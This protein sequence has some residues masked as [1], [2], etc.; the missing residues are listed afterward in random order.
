ML[1]EREKNNIR[2][3]ASDNISE[4]GG[5]IHAFSTRIGGVSGPPFASLN[6]NAGDADAPEN[7]ARNRSIF[8]DAIGL[9]CAEEK[10]LVTLNQ[11]HGD[12]VIAI[13]AD[14]DFKEKN[15]EPPQGGDAMITDVVGTPIGILTADCL[16]IL[17][18]DP[19]KKAVGAAHAGWKGT[20]LKIGA[21]TAAAMQERFGSKPGDIRAAFGPFIG[22]CCYAVKDDV[23]AKFKKAFGTDAAG[24][25]SPPLQTCGGISLDIGRANVKTLL[26][27]GLLKENI[28][29]NGSCTACGSALFFSHRKENGRTGRQINVIMLTEAR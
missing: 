22:P 8:A 2:Y 10:R 13:D 18:Y 11:V 15:S 29:A 23:H 3:F 5:V 6:L 19:V 16:P 7:I 20:Y 9:S 12:T 14:Y 28:S 27:A 4:A 26:D 17:L 24:F 21:L 1:R 25:F